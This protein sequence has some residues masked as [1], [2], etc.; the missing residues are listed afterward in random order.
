MKLMSDRLLTVTILS[1][2]KAIHFTIFLMQSTQIIQ[3][4]GLH[5][6][7]QPNTTKYNQN[8]QNNHT[9]AKHTACG[10]QYDC[11][12]DQFQAQDISE[13][14]VHTKNRV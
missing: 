2:H 14:N 3:V 9:D 11:S 6:Q 8:N 7:I 13:A 10:K 4:R 12:L 1:S 5:N